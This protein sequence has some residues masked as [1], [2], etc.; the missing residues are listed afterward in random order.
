MEK[1]K[2]PRAGLD[3]DLNQDSPIYDVPVHTINREGEE[4]G[5]INALLRMEITEEET[6]NDPLQIKEIRKGFGSI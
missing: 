4:E 3:V 2:K 5:E 1:T 6:C